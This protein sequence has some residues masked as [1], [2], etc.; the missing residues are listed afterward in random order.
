MDELGHHRFLLCLDSSF[1]R[2]IRK[3]LITCWSD[4]LF[5]VLSDTLYCITSQ[6]PMNQSILAMKN[7]MRC[8]DWEEKQSNK[9]KTI[10]IHLRYETN[11]I[12]TP[13]RT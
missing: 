10:Y 4:V 5:L 9:G 11:I 8:N 3:I 12:I 2:K 7:S 1:I 6:L 13:L